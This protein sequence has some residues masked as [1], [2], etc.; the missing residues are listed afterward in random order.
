V[1]SALVQFDSWRELWSTKYGWSLVGK[2]AAML[3]LLAV[4]GLNAFVLQQRVVEAAREVNG[5]DG[6]REAVGRLQRFLSNTVRAEAVLG[7]AVL[8]AVAVLIQLQ[9]PR[10]AAEA[11]RRAAEAIAQPPSQPEA[12]RFR[13]AAEVEGLIM[14]L[15]IEPARVGENTFVLGLGSEFGAIGEVIEA[16]LDFERA[17]AGSS[18]LPLSLSG[19]QEYSARGANLSLPGE[20]AV[21]VNVRRR[22]EDDVRAT[23]DVA[24]AEPGA[25]PG[26]P[27]VLEEEESES[28]WRWPFEGRRSAGAI[29]VLAAVPFIAAGWVAWR[30]RWT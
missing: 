30:V 11:E 6:V 17:E 12:G 20:W 26:E 27:A 9:P 23:F 18:R 25:A 10:A 16:R 19:S 14:S 22:G 2:L 5:G 3:P 28:V 24:V 7:I 1:L 29:A 8:V 13:E 21:T 4:G 15:R